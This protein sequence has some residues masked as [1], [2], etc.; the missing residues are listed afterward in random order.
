MLRTSCYVEVVLLRLSLMPSCSVLDLLVD[1]AEHMRI[2]DKYPGAVL[3][4]TK[5][6][7]TSALNFCEILNDERCQVS[8]VI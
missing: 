4:L 8:F 7:S 3:V 1:V 6:L 5:Q 2:V